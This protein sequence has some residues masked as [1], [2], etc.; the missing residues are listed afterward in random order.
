MLRLWRIAVIG[1]PLV[2]DPEL[3]H[4]FDQRSRRSE[5]SE[6]NGCTRPVEYRGF[7]AVP[8]HSELMKF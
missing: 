7:E 3:C 2:G 5:G 4:G 1:Q 8:F 6:A